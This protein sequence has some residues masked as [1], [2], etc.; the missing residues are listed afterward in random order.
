MEQPPGVGGDRF[1][2]APLGLGIEGAEGQRRFARARHAGENDQGIAGNLEIDILEIVLACPADTNKA[3]ETVFVGLV[4]GGLASPF[5]RK[6]LFFHAQRLVWVCVAALAMSRSIGTVFQ[7]ATPAPI[8]FRL[9]G[10]NRAEPA[11]GSIDD[12]QP[13]SQL[14]THEVP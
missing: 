9:S 4:R 10:E 11:R 6:R 3:G 7:T 12:D 8:H 5:R 1:E 2:I 14:G 13:A